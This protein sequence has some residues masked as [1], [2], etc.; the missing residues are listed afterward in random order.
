[1]L[2]LVGITCNKNSIHGDTRA[3][4]PSGLRF[5]T[6]WVTQRGM[7]PDDL[8]EIA[9]IVGDTLTSMKAFQVHSAAGLVGRVRLPASALRSAQKRVKKL[10]ERR[11]SAGYGAFSYPHY[12]PDGPGATR[13][14]PLTAFPPASEKRAMGSATSRRATDRG[15]R[16][17][18]AR[19]RCGARRHEPRAGPRRRG[20]RAGDALQLALSGDLL[21]LKPGAAT[22]ARAL[23]A[24]GR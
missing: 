2:D 5:G 20:E 19:E 4:Y 6:C 13:R 10:V 16:D 14:T 12:E 1:V 17:G 23:D 18:R 24:E 22:A 11:D 3:L 9:S 7:G 8:A 15:R 21:R